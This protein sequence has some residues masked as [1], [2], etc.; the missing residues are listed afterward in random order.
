MA[1][2]GYWYCPANIDGT[3]AVGEEV[4][5]RPQPTSVDYGPRQNYSTHSSD[6]KLIKQRFARNP[7]LKKWIWENYRPTIVLY[8]NQYWDLFNL[9]E[10]ILVTVNSGSPYVYL[11]DECTDGLGTYYVASGMLVKDWV[12]CRI[13]DVDRFP[14]DGGG[15]L[16]Y[17]TTELSFT[18]DEDDPEPIL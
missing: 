18:V 2:N 8:E 15:P 12:R 6:A 13:I 4:E 16:T 1:C 17:E 7:K 11:K 10:Q 14:R 3:R 5:I 9:Q